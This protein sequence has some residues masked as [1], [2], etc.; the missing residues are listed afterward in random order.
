MRKGSLN[1]TTHGR[2]RTEA[3]PL[4]DLYIWLNFACSCPVYQTQN[5]V[6]SVSFFKPDYTWWVSTQ[7]CL[8]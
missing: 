2:S 4:T 1:K 6:T 8:M 3:Q 5:E 7:S